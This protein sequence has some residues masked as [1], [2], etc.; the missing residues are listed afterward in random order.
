MKTGKVEDHVDEVKQRDRFG[1]P[2]KLIKSSLMKYEKIGSTGDDLMYRVLT[3]QSG[4]KFCLQ[5]CRFPATQNRLGIEPGSRWDG[6][7]RSNQYEKRWFARQ[8]DLYQNKS[9]FHKWATNDM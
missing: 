4:K 6:V 8:N 2:L 1:D 9:A 3:T 7:D 5:K